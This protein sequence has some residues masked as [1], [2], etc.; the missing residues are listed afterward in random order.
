MYVPIA[1]LKSLFLNREPKPTKDQLTELFTKKVVDNVFR[2]IEKAKLENLV[3][4]TWKE[5]DAI[6][7]EAWGRPAYPEE[8]GF[9]CSFSFRCADGSRNA[10]TPSEKKRDHADWW[11][12]RE[13]DKTYARNFNEGKWPYWW[14]TD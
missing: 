13:L 14:H 4:M 2:H 12:M 11:K 7:K 8:R 6:Y 9:V 5:I 1:I 3:D 10:K